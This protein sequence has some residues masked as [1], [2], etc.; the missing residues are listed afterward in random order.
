[1]NPF[2]MV[3]M[4]A[5]TLRAGRAGKAGEVWVKCFDEALFGLQIALA[6]RAHI[7]GQLAKMIEAAPEGPKD[8][9]DA[10]SVIVKPN[11]QVVAAL[12]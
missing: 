11:M 8:K 9:S 2:E 6:N 3:V 4:M 1:M 5:T 10:E 7:E 12:G